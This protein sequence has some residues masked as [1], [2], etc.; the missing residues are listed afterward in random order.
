MIW[1]CALIAI[2]PLV[3]LGAERLVERFPAELKR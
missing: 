3:W 1:L 2:C